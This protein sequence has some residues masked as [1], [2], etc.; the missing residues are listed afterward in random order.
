MNQVYNLFSWKSKILLVTFLIL[1]LFPFT[2]K[3]RSNIFVNMSSLSGIMWVDSKY[4][5]VDMK[6]FQNPHY[7]SMVAVQIDNM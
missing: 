2:E 6:N 3:K 1:D 4:Y 5:T 7:Y